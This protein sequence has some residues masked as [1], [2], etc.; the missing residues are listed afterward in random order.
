MFK[1]LEWDI[2]FPPRHIMIKLANAIDCVLKMNCLQAL[3][4][5]MV[6]LSVR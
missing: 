4:L 2:V 3:V 5:I 6:V 1:S